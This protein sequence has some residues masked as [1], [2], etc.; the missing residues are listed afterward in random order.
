MGKT[1]IL[2]AGQGS[3]FPGMGKDFY[4]QYPEFREVFDLLTEEQREIAFSGS[5]EQLK[6]TVNTQPILLAFGVGIYQVLKSRGF[7][8]DMTAGLSL[9]EYSALTASGVFTA[10]QAV[11]LIHCRAEAM[12][13]A[14]AGV[15]TEM[16]AILGLDRDKLTGCLNR[17]SSAGRVE[18]ANFNCPGQIVISGEREGIEEA[19]RLAKEAGAKKCMRLP[20]S[21]PFHTSYMKPAAEV[22]RQR[23]QNESFGKMEF[24]VYFNCTG[25]PE[26]PAGGQSEAALISELL[27]R[28]VQSS[29]YMEDTIRNMIDAG[30]D[31]FVEIGPG[32]TLSGFVK[33]TD[34]SVR[35]VTVTT[36]EDLQAFLNE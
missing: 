36:V 20:V 10:E 8:P 23:F 26:T 2:F 7:R 1:A 27:V 18:A 5:R 21:G 30:A 13:E 35:T 34:R 25:K 15:E 16:S 6:E 24:P 17:A 4:E 22:L 12:E 31:H 29:V 28:Q 19:E 33:R 32:K 14:S 3:Q 9:G 11:S